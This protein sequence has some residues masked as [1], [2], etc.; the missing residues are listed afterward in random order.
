M[1]IWALVGGRSFRSRLD[2]T[3]TGGRG[4]RTSLIWE[5]DSN[6]EHVPSSLGWAGLV[7]RLAYPFLPS[8][9][10][11]F[12][13][14]YS[15]R[16]GR[17]LDKHRTLLLLGRVSLFLLRVSYSLFVSFHLDFPLSL[18]FDRRIPRSTAAQTW[19]SWS[20]KRRDVKRE[21]RFCGWLKQVFP[22][23]T[24]VGRTHFN[25]SQEWII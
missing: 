13:S 22:L 3:R 5:Y 19:G 24:H 12:L 4:W 18:S 6:S 14:S 1:W 15:F 25:R 7:R 10:V 23:R 17:F 8:S 20:L 9:F 11:S 2:R 21:I 16:P